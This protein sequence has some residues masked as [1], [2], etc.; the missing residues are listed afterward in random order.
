MAECYFITARGDQTRPCCKNSHQ[1]T[2]V[3][4]HLLVPLLVSLVYLVLVTMAML[5][6]RCW[7]L[8]MIITTLDFL[9]LSINLTYSDHTGKIVYK[10]KTCHVFSKLSTKVSRVFLG[11]EMPMQ[12]DSTVGGPPI[13]SQL[14]L[15]LWSGT[16]VLSGLWRRVGGKWSPSVWHVEPIPLWTSNCFNR[17]IQNKTLRVAEYQNQYSN[18]FKV[19]SGTE[20]SVRECKIIVGGYLT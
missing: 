15:H 1:N 8:I 16:N 17:K 4:L 3:F 7:W 13:H 12:K 6:L 9:L 14:S 5:T 20:S 19:G 10:A 2:V 11:R 18:T